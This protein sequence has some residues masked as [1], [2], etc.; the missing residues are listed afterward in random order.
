MSKLLSR[1]HV[2]LENAE[3]NYGRIGLDDCYMDACCYNL[4]QSIE[5]SLKFLVE[6]TGQ[7]YAE[8][9]DVRANLNILNKMDYHVPNE[10][11]L[12]NMASTLYSWETESRYRDSFVVAIEDVEEAFVYARSLLMEAKKKVMTEI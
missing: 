11:E 9:H 3:H 10:K 2:S 4:Q 8:N 5:F 7:Q 1:A 12:R 6:M